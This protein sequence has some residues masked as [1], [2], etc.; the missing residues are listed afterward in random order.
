MKTLKPFART[1]TFLYACMM[2]GCAS[3]PPQLPPSKA[4]SNFVAFNLV[5]SAYTVVADLAS[6]NVDSSDHQ[7]TIKSKGRILVSAQ[8]KI[9]N[10]G[11]IAVR[12]ACHLLM[13]DGTGPTNG[14]TE[15]SVRPATWFTIANAAYDLTVPI[16]GYATKPPG[17]YNVV[18]ECE[19]LAASGGTTGQLDNMIVWEA[20]E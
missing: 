20:S 14:L 2:L 18:V 19:Q 11:G 7:I 10:P 3:A 9:S 6:K 12:G 5:N 8:A 13:S 1:I 16:L 15:I 4:I 17:T